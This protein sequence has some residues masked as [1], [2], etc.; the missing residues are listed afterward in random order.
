MNISKYLYFYYKSYFISNDDDNRC[1]YLKSTENDNRYQDLQTEIEFPY[2]ICAI[3]WHCKSSILN[4][5][6]KK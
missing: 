4:I 3:V 6:R 1:F 2:N 5:I